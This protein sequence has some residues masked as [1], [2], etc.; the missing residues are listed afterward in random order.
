MKDQLILTYV[1][2]IKFSI[3]FFSLINFYSL[4]DYFGK[5]TTKLERYTRNEKEYFRT[6]GLE[7][8]GDIKT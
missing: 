1:S 8:D 4:D 6:A 5:L 7:I 2:F 3:N